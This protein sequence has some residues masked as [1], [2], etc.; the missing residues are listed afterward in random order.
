MEESVRDSQEP[1]DGLTEAEYAKSGVCDGW[2][3]FYEEICAAFSLKGA[4]LRTYSPLTLAFIGDAVYELVIRSLLVGNGNGKTSRL[5]AHASHL[6]RAEA[7]A[8]MI[9]AILPELTEEEQDQYRRG[10]NAKPPTMPKNASAEDYHRATGFEALMGSLY[11]SGRTQRMLA[12]IG[13]GLKAIEAP[14]VRD[15]DGQSGSADSC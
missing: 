11:L 13:A 4:D 9:D 2:D 8:Q 15:A 3:G 7:Q 5:H 10:R 12:L 6:E 14:E 1:E